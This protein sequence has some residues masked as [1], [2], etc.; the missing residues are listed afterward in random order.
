[1]TSR[2]FEGAGEGPVRPHLA[3]LTSEV[4]DLRAD[5]ES[6]FQRVQD[7]HDAYGIQA[8]ATARLTSEGGLAVLLINDTGAPSV[9]GS[10]VQAS[11]S[12][13]GAVSLSAPYECIGVI[14]N[15]GVA[16]GDPVWVVVSGVA[17]VLLKDTTAATR[18]YWVGVSSTL[19]RADA[20]NAAPPGLVDAHFTEV[21][22]C[23]QSATAGTDVLV[24]VALHFN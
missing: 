14:Y 13:D 2:F 1:M 20:T 15:S 4:G 9:K 22:H 21:G 18:G 8:P 12:V 7:E 11:A 3:K 5:V 24:K 19:G 17:E 16:D 6:G 23:L 10:M